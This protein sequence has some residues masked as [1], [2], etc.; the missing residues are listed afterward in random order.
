MPVPASSEQITRMV[1][2]PPAPSTRSTRSA[3]A[4]AVIALPGSSMVVS[5]HRARSQP[6]LASSYSTC[7]RKVSQSVTLDGL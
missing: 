4:W 3:I 6:R 5:S 2:S 7:R 1:P